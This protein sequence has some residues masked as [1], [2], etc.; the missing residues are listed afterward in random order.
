MFGAVSVPLSLS[1]NSYEDAN[2]IVREH[3]KLCLIGGLGYPNW[4]E[5]DLLHYF[6][7]WIWVEWTSHG[8]SHF[9]PNIST[10]NYFLIFSR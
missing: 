1:L 10:K 5:M 7:R 4:L 9:I 2:K 6:R 3:Y 8:V